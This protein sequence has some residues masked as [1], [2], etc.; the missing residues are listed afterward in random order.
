VD[1][2]SATAVRLLA[3]VVAAGVATIGCSE[4]RRGAA[5]VDATLEGDRT[6]VLVISACNADENRAAVREEPDS[7]TVSVTTDDPVGGDDCADG[8]T[9]H[10]SGP[11]SDRELIDGATGE[12][13]DVRRTP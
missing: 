10:L 6:L 2:Q 4:E 9:V 5:I 1:F 7:V 12:P 8:V 3:V 11:L 13:V